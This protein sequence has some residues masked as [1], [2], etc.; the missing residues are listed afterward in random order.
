MAATKASDSTTFPVDEVEKA[1]APLPARNYEAMV[2]Y[3]V[4]GANKPEAMSPCNPA[5]TPIE[6]PPGVELF[7]RNGFVSAVHMAYA[8]HYPLVIS[9]DAI[10]QC[11]AQGLA[12]HINCNA[13]KLRNLFV[14]HEGKKEIVVRR[15]DFRKGSPSN[16]WPEVFEEFSAQIRQHVGKKTHDLLTPDFSTTGP[17]E[18]AA[19]QVV[20]MDCFKEYFSYTCN[21]SCGIPEIT[22]EGTVDDWVKLREKVCGISQYDLDWWTDALTPVLDQFVSA[23]SG[24]I[25]QS[26]WSKIYKRHGGSGGPYIQGWILTLFPYTTFGQRNRFLTSWSKD[27][28]FGG[29]TTDAFTSGVVSTPFKWEYFDTD[30]PMYFYAGFMSVTQDP[31]TLA[32]RPE[33]GW[34]VADNTD[35]KSIKE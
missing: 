6:K 12:K 1:A 23:A 7:I 26:F 2:C 22:L 21:T 13:D 19:A 28:M 30:F 27:S 16:P 32:L 29:L 17:T 15:D 4:G 3:R 31:A 25:D 10:W 8:W 14:E 5:G 9:P 11:I 34:A 35:T 20:L 24:D 18:K 33:I